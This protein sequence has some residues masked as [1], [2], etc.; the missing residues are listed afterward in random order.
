[1]LGRAVVESRGLLDWSAVRDV[2]AAHDSNREDYTDLLL[3]LV[4]LEIWC[5]M[6][7][8]G[9]SHEDVS[10]ELHELMAAA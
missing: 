8:D 1:M 10:V 2:M 6:F 4:N 3:A 5:R 9:R 7:L